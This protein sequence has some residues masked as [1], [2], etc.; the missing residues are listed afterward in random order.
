MFHNINFNFLNNPDK[1]YKLYN[2]L[3]ECLN[4]SNRLNH[5]KLFFGFCLVITINP[6]FGKREKS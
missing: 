6:F 5:Y 4:K 2:L 3:N 1:R